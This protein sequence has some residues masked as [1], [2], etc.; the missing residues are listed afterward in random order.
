MSKDVAN[1]RWDDD[2]PSWARRMQR[3]TSGLG[4]EAQKDARNGVG[5]AFSGVKDGREEVGHWPFGCNEA[6]GTGEG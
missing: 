4:F 5:V 2:M 6:I 3:E 1:E